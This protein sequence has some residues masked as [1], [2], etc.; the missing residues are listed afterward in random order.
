MAIKF[1]REFYKELDE[2]NLGFFER[3]IIW[4][5]TGKHYIPPPKIELSEKELFENVLKIV[6]H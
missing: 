5:E 3:F 4:K 6:K 2:N 1:D